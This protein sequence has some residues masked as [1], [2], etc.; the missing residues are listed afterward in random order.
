M[1]MV[2]FGVHQPAIMVRI[3]QY[4]LC[5]LDFLPLLIVSTNNVQAQRCVRLAHRLIFRNQPVLVLVHT[6][7]P[8]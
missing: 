6:F 7:R 3:R 4:I 2:S 8:K 1:I 5:Y